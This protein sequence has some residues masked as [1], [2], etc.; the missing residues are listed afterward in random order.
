MTNH[1]SQRDSLSDLK[2]L[3]ESFLA[4]LKGILENKLIGVYLYGAVVFPETKFTG[5]VDFHV[6]LS[7][8]LTEA[9]K[10]QI[11]ALH[12]ELV[13]NY[14]PLGEEMDGYYLL[15][16]DARGKEPPRSQMWS[17]AVDNSWALHRQHIRAGRCIVL[18]GPDPH[19]IYPP[20]GWT[21][22]EA[23]LDG[24]LD[25]VAKNLQRYHAYCVLN[26]C[27]LM[28][29]FSSRDV[30]TSKT[31]SAE[32]ARAMFPQWAAIINCAEQAYA[33]KDTLACQI[34][35]DEQLPD[36]YAFAVEVISRGK[37]RN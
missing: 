23:A 2:R 12:Q 4:G 32:W 10:E 5:D 22:L 17:R 35:M 15:E 29:S 37:S 21:E 8:P 19:S 33:G 14:P 20:A 31:A 34:I 6:I 9:E 30:V 28:Y 27:R 25:Y 3:S 36:L 16:E 1:T 7:S 11:D 26:L 18:H 24:E 13:R